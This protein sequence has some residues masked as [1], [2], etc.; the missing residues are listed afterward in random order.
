MPAR[1]LQ[2]TFRLLGSGWVLSL[3]SLFIIY[4]LTVHLLCSG[5]FFCSIFSFRTST[6]CVTNHSMFD[7]Q[8]GWNIIECN[9]TANVSVSVLVRANWGAEANGRQM[10]KCRPGVQIGQD[11]QDQ[12]ITV[13]PA[14][15]PSWQLQWGRLDVHLR[16][17]FSICSTTSS[18]TKVRT[19]KR[20]N[21]DMLW[22]VTRVVDMKERIDWAEK[23]TRTVFFFLAKSAYQASSSLLRAGEFISRCLSV[24]TEK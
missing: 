3:S 18:I 12:S 24:L 15:H 23:A 5:S 19:S 13:T 17:L 22:F 10:Y 16:V 20:I 7:S 6:T 2:F 9:T 21:G 8:N 4:L 14:T 11:H 1:F